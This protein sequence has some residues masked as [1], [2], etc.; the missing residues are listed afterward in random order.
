MLLQ[1]LT[2]V[3]SDVFLLCEFLLTSF[4]ILLRHGTGLLFGGQQIGGKSD[5][6]L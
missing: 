2:K 6:L 5:L 1:L 3:F 4:E